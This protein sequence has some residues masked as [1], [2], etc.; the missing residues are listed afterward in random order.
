MRGAVPSRLISATR[1]PARC[2]AR[3]SHDA[4]AVRRLLRR[5]SPSERPSPRASSERPTRVGQ[6]GLNLITGPANAGKVA[7]LL[8]RYLEVLPR[9]PYLIMPNRSDVERVERDLLAIQP[10]LLG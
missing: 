7:L 2:R 1:V 5:A 9:E 10:A 4:A 3:R 8:H 6:L